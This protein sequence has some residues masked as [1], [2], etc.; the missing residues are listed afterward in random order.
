MSQSEAE[1][2]VGGGCKAG[3]LDKFLQ[4][5]DTYKV[6]RLFAEQPQGGHPLNGCVDVRKSLQHGG[7]TRRPLCGGWRTLQGDG[8]VGH[9][10]TIVI[11]RE[12][13]GTTVKVVYS[14]CAV[15]S[16]LVVKKRGSDVPVLS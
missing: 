2:G 1:Q 13:P 12:K 9:P 5:T 14:I 10:A 15:F 8:R 16:K 11:L 3:S 7:L 4:F 6:R